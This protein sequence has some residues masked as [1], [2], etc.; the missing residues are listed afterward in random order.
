MK[1]KTLSIPLIVLM[2]VTSANA[3]LTI[4][5]PDEMAVGET[6]IVGIDAVGEDAMLIGLLTFEGEINVDISEAIFTHD[7]V[8]FPVLEDHTDRPALPEYLASF[9]IFDP[10]FAL[11][12]EFV[13]VIIPPRIPNGR[14]IDSIRMTDTGQGTAVLTLFDLAWDEVI[15]QKEVAL[16]IPE[17]TTLTLFAAA[18][19]L[20][21]RRRP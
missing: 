8:L 20:L 12:F 6:A 17:P 19:A 10:A 3:T 14:F 15:N 2:T 18:I 5:A 13:S 9:D 1:M 16:G 21:R 7:L 4:V 11:Y